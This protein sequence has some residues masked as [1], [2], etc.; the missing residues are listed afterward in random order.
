MEL[1]ENGLLDYYGNQVLFV[2]GSG[3]AEQCFTEKAPEAKD[4]PIKMVDLTSAFLILSIG[5]TLSI[6][7]FLIELIV[8]KYQRETVR[9]TTPVKKIKKHSYDV[10]E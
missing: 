7:C 8:S 1:R 2:A 3:G 9:T 4:V 5:L 10:E 6:L